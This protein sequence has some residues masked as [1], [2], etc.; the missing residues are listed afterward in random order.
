M[1]STDEHEEHVCTL[2]NAD[3]IGGDIFG[4]VVGEEK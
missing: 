2:G 1:G 4:K 3:E